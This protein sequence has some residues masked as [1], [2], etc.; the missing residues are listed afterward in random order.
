MR[1]LRSVDLARRQGTHGGFYPA[2]EVGEPTTGDAASSTAKLRI[3]AAKRRIAS[4]NPADH[5]TAQP[6]R[7]L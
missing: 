7:V 2:G 5:A 1:A 3:S 6:Y 4:E